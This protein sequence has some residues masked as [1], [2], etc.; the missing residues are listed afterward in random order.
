MHLPGCSRP[1]AIGPQAGPGVESEGIKSFQMGD[2]GTHKCVRNSAW[3]IFVFMILR[4]EGGSRIPGSKEYLKRGKVTIALLRWDMQQDADMTLKME[5]GNESRHHLKHI[6]SVKDLNRLI[7]R[8]SDRVV[9]SL[10]GK[11]LDLKVEHV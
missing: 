7:C 2:I 1:G 11:R 6:K 4:A 5:S 8:K 9:D 3:C 10:K